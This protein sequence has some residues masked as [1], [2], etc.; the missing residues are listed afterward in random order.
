[1]ATAARTESVF[2]FDLTTLDPFRWVLLANP[3]NGPSARL[4]AR[5]AQQ[6][7]TRS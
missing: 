3:G 1:M 5:N 7:S 6:R 2:E 4:L